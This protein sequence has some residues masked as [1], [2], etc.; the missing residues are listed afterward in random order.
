M[1]CDTRLKPRQTIKQR[2]EEVKKVVKKFVDGLTSGRIKTK[3]SPQGAVVFTGITDEERDG[4]T[5]GCAFRQ[6]MGPQGSQLARAAIERAEALA[7]R[8]VDRKVIG[9]AGG[10][11]HS[12][13]GG[14]TFHKH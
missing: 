11:V 4:V 7:G 12:H 10:H 5:D 8:K 2:A 9:A 1:P 14:V 13:D 6:I 3:V